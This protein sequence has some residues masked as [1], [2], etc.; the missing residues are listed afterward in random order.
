MTRCGLLAVLLVAGCMDNLFPS[1]E[2]SCV[3]NRTYETTLT[4][5]YDAPTQFQ[6]DRC[7]VDSDVCTE[8]CAI[9][10]MHDNRSGTQTSCSVRFHDNGDVDVKVGYQEL[11]GGLPFCGM[12]QPVDVGSGG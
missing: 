7:R 3:A 5:P 2:P 10:M 8:L 11:L 4:T 6:I 1:K 12:P 9:T